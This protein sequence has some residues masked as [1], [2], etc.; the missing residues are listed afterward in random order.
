M[1]SNPETFVSDPEHVAILVPVWQSYRWMAPLTL[2]LLDR[3]WPSHPPVWFCGLG[4]DPHLP[5][6][7][8]S[9]GTDL[10]NWSAMVL[11]GVE[12]LRR[13]GIGLVY[14]VAEE[15]VPLGPCNVE[16]LDSILP[17][18]MS[19]LPAVYISLM[20]WDNRRFPSKSP[21][22]GSDRHRLKHL[23][24]DRDPRF[25]LHPA[26]WR[27]DALEACC[28][29]ALADPDRNGSAWHFEKINDRDHGSHPLAW[30][31][32]C[33]Q[34][35]SAALRLHPP[36]PVR[37]AAASLEIMVFRKLMALA[38]LMRNPTLAAAYLRFLRFDDVYC[39]GPY[40]MF[41]SG[42]MAKGKINPYFEANLR[43]SDAGRKLLMEIQQAM[44]AC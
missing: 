42:I 22:L 12:H 6:L 21:V 41:F 32:Q 34:I 27:I 39:D 37:R 35:D 2:R 15:H 29:L 8:V 28:R 9:P 26:L 13:K 14:L 18:L 17:M 25:H 3:F 31:S 10:T 30:K 24:G 7:P 44:P 20:G 36:G 40:P 16:A 5:S 43:R 19:G 38:P 11:E 4:P 1:S 23:V 33:Y